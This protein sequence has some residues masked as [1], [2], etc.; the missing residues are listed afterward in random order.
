MLLQ[1]LLRPA[2]IAVIGATP[3]SFIGRIALENCRNH[4]Y[5]GVV[6]PVNGRHAQVAG[7]D[8]VASLADLDHVPDV[9]VVQVR[10]ARV[11][12][13]V[14][15]AVAAGVRNFVIPGGGFTDSG[16]DATLLVEG[17]R[18]LQAEAGIQVVGPNCMGRPPGCR[19][20][21]EACASPRPAAWRPRLSR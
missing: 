1:S 6:T 7:F 13:A 11:L 4:G 20:R 19:P 12:N 2:S 21:P 15:D 17:L 5:A 9:A 16:E 10:T 8:A 3:S 18:K 14:A